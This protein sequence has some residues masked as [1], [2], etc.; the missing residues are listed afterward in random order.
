MRLTRLIR[1]GLHG[2]WGEESKHLPAAE[3]ERGLAALAPGKD[4]GTLGLIVS[5]GDN[6]ARTTPERVALTTTSGIPGDAWSRDCPDNLDSQ[7]AIMRLDVARMI[8]NGQPL[9]LFGDNLLIDLDLSTENLP[10]GSRLRI[11]AA[12]FEVTPEP[13]NGC[14]KFK[15]RFGIDALK[16][17]ADPR[18]KTMRLRGLYLKVS[19]P[20][21]IAVGD[22]VAVISRT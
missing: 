22:P 21:E 5:R 6:G 11:G 16:L 20:G 14:I 15:K 2:P 1:H 10:T 19:E 3:L 7:L 4:S 9:T 13:H 12:T 17:T 18:F 8:A